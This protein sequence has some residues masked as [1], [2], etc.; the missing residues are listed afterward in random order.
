MATTSS[1]STP[2]ASS[3]SPARLP[4]RRLLAR[5]KAPFSST[6]RTLTDYYIRP[7][8]PHRQYRPGDRVKG[9]IVLTVLKPIR[10]THLVVRLCGSVR[11]Y[12]NGSSSESAVGDGSR[13][14]SRGG[15]LGPTPGPGYVPLFQDETVLCGEGRLEAGVYE[16]N[17]ELEFPH[18]PLPSSIDFERGT[19]AYTLQSTLTR[20]TT[21]TPTSKCDR[22]LQ[23]VETIDVGPLQQ[24]KLRKISLEPVRRTSKSKSTKKKGGPGPK[25]DPTTNT[26]T[27]SRPG[28]PDTPA[29]V[30]GTTDAGPEPSSSSVVTE[31][32]QTSAGSSSG[33]SV[34]LGHSQPSSASGK[35][36]D[37]RDKVKRYASKKPITAA[38]ELQRSG[39]LRGDAIPID[40]SVSHTKAIKSIN[41][42]IVTLYRQCRIDPHPIPLPTS[43]PGKPGG[44]QPDHLYPK[45]K[46][47]LTGLSLSSTG[48]ASVYRKDLSQCFAHLIVD[49]HSL[50]AKIKASV[51][52]PEDAF[53][54]ITSVP[55][56]IITFKY[57]IEVVMDLNGKLAGQDSFLPRLGGS[58]LSTDVLGGHSGPDMADPLHHTRTPLEGSIF[59]TDQVRREKGVVACL[60]E[61]VVGTVNSAKKKNRDG[62]HRAVS[63]LTCFNSE[64]L[65]TAATDPNAQQ[66]GLDSGHEG[67]TPGSD[68][69]TGAA[70]QNDA[71][72]RPNASHMPY[73]SRPDA[74]PVPPPEFDSGPPQD[75]KS[76]IRQAEERL[77]PSAPPVIADA[78]PTPGPSAPI[79][80]SEEYGDHMNGWPPE[81]NTLPV[82]S[83][84]VPTFT[85]P[86]P[87]GLATLP[88]H[89]TEEAAANDDK[90]ELERRRLQAEASAPD[91]F[92]D[93]DDDHEPGVGSHAPAIEGPSAPTLTEDDDPFLG[94]PPP[95]TGS[96]HIVAGAVSEDPEALPRYV[97]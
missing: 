32:S 44:A 8:E 29:S 28:T 16:F 63:G 24:P 70:A 12:K 14:P 15:R 23:F 92:P 65:P 49:P 13:S 91:Q 42:I 9:S 50:T 6:T 56:A 97:K 45:S 35:R 69:D 10:I 20:P 82:S 19:I 57:Y 96:G 40:I 51:R 79:I 11:T 95:P 77:L 88:E 78:G 76:R 25:E 33:G 85:T 90:Q 73:S 64:N 21:I 7:Q 4:G 68:V 75:E 31:P 94:V 38:I 61:I 66:D 47:G 48:G 2:T 54:T 81:A 39:C 1:T 80:E 74:P 86:Q 17:Y 53:P 22:K 46:S 67:L 18:W 34:P 87:S 41:G 71:I 52:V 84:F 55:G 37:G 60:F 30:S 72:A 36:S 62:P 5:I 26:G 89:H 83:P 27:T 43:R 59:A 58:T 3:S 93:G